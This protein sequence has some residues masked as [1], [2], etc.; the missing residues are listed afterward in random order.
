M[1]DLV[2][3]LIHAEQQNVQILDSGCQIG[4]PGA[5]GFQGCL[6]TV[7]QELMFISAT[8]TRTHPYKSLFDIR[9]CIIFHLKTQTLP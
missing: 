2:S 4:F 5:L 1:G 9:F 7:I 6:Y 3:L 8:L